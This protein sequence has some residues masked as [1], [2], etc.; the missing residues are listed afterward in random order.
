MIHIN[1]HK[2]IPVYFIS[3]DQYSKILEVEE[4]VSSRHYKSL[5]PPLN[6]L[7]YWTGT[8]ADLMQIA[9]YITRLSK[10]ASLRSTITQMR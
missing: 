3:L 4:D 7:L 9:T 6:V 10:Q 2:Q 8:Q 1:T 5:S